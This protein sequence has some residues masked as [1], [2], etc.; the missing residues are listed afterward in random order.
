MGANISN[1][2]REEANKTNEIAKGGTG[3][4]LKTIERTDLVGAK[5]KVTEKENERKFAEAERISSKGDKIINMVITGGQYSSSTADT[6]AHNLR[7][8]VDTK[9]ASH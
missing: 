9:A 7:M 8:N 5:R 3:R 4:S 1:K 2:K 6:A